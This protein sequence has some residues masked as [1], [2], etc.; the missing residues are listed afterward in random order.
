MRVA[1][2][3]VA[4][5]VVLGL[6][7]GAAFQDGQ[8]SQPGVNLTALPPLARQELPALSALLQHR[9]PALPLLWVLAEVQAE[10]AW[11]PRA[12]S[13]AGAA[14]LLQSDQRYLA[15]SWRPGR[16]VAR[17][18]WP[19]AGAPGLGFS[20]PLGDG[21]RL[22]VRELA[23]G[24][25]ASAG[26]RQADRRAG[27]RRRLP[28]RGL[29]PGHRLPHRVTHTGRGPLRWPM[30]PADQGLPGRDPHMGPALLGARPGLGS[31]A[32][33]ANRSP[34]V[35]AAAYVLIPPAPAAASRPPRTGC[36]ARSTAL[37]Q[38]RVTCWDAHAQNP[39][40]DHPLGKACDY[41]TSRSAGRVRLRHR[42][43]PGL[44][45]GRVATHLRRA[46]QVAY[47]IWQGRIWSQARRDEGWRPYS[48]GGI[49]DPTDPTGGHYDHVH[50]SL[51][52]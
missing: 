42:P 21:D 6:L 51:T 43:G 5:P 18:P 15:R 36:S 45:A 38:T 41:L 30:R 10:S 48:G 31:A 39:I 32:A 25:P 11:N 20:S 17:P 28:H 47:V 40:S 4:A 8:A 1:A 23:L 22:D 49:Y 19:R 9:C 34:A 12:Y 13:S 2:V 35:R 33:R 29:L 46:P 14:G 50:V 3:L 44:A 52:R 16:V 24:G 27:R 37:N 7:F 26:V